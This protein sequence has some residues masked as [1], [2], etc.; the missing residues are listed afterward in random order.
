MLLT[1]KNTLQLLP[2]IKFELYENEA[3]LWVPVNF[4]IFTLLLFKNHYRFQFKS[5]THVSAVDCPQNF[6]RFM[7]VYELLSVKYNFR[8][9]IKV[10]LNE[11]LSIE[12]CKRIFLSASWWECE[13]WDMFGVFFIRHL[14]LTRLL[15]D[16]GFEGYPLRKD[17]PLGGFYECRYCLI[18]NRIIFE[19]VELAQEYRVFDYFSP[20][21]NNY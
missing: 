5:L 2:I 9:K 8:L 19:N 3:S 14:N 17:F 6:Y 11:F 4:L 1:L 13:I 21:E 20:W 10:L 18:K 16:Y 7:L 15:T 12:S